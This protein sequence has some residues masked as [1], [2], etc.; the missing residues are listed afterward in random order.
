MRGFGNG[1]G[2]NPEDFSEPPD[3]YRAEWLNEPQHN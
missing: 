2:R 3:I 1:K